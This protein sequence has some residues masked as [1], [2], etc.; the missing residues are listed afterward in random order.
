MVDICLAAKSR[1]IKYPTIFT[2]TEVYTTQVKLIAPK[3][4]TPVTINR[5]MIDF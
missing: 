5:E 1:G 4:T 2:D 3:T